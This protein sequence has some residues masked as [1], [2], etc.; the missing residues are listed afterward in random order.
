MT[1]YEQQILDT[2]KFYDQVMLVIERETSE[3]FNSYVTEDNL[4]R[5]INNPVTEGIDEG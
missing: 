4:H 3:I 1:N 5:I 2:G